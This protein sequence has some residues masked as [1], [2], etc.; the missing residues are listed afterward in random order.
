MTRAMVRA[1]GIVVR[2]GIRTMSIV[3]RVT[4]GI[5]TG[6]AMMRGTSRAQHRGR[7]PVN[8]CVHATVRTL[9]RL[10]AVRMVGRAGMAVHMGRI[11]VVAM[12]PGSRT[13]VRHKAAG[14]NRRNGENGGAGCRVTIH[15]ATIVITVNGEAV[16]VIASG[17]PGHG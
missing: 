9:V 12:V 17:S 13:P 11:M 7:I 15:R 2:A 14:R 8:G 3:I 6:L 16:G 5:M 4:M 1:G 10:V